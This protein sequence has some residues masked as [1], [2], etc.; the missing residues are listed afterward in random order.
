MSAPTMCISAG[1]RQGVRCCQDIVSWYVV[2]T[3]NLQEPS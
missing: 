2:A 1:F 3:D